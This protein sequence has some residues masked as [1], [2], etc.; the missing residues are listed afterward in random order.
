LFLPLT[1]AT[2]ARVWLEVQRPELIH[3][4]DHLRLAGLGDDFTVSDG[5]QM[6]DPGLLTA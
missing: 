4:E 1:A 6:L 2:A 3:A 5:I